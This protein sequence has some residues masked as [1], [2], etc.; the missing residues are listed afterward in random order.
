MQGTCLRQFAF[1]AG[2]L[3]LSRSQGSNVHLLCLFAHVLLVRCDGL[4]DEEVTVDD[5]EQRH[6]VDKDAVDQ[7]IRSGEQVF[8][9]VIGTA[10]GHVALGY[11]AVKD[12]Y[13]I[14]DNLYNIFLNNM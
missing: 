1:G 8:G 4:D 13:L 14:T 9:Q 10:G 6:E 12:E 5:Q 3:V 7:D 11:V 2:V